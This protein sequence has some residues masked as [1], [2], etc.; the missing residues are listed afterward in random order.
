ME[1]QKLK[2]IAVLTTGGDC[3]GLNAA[4]RAVVRT[5]CYYKIEVM[6]AKR[7]FEGL[8][9]DVFIPMPPE[10]VSNIL[11]RGGTILKTARSERFKTDEGR[12]SA[13]DNITKNQID[14]LVVMG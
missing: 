9:D 4:I 11:Q 8:I 7:G 1:F 12:K 2:R 14:A 3:P 6:G 10:S 13:F 5:A